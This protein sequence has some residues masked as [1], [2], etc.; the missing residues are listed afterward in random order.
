MCGIYGFTGKNK[1]LANKLSEIMEHRGPDQKGIKEFDNFTLGFRRLAIMDLSSKG[2][3]PMQNKDKSLHITFNGEVFNFQE[4]KEKLIKK[5][6]KFKSKTDSEV[7]LHAYEE[8]GSKCLSMFNGQFALCIYDTKNNKIFLARDRIGIRPLYYFKNGKNFM[9]S[10]EVKGILE[11]KFIKK[12]IDQN[13]LNH[14]LC[15]GFTSPTQSIFKNIKK[16]PPGNYASVNLE[17]G[18]MVIKPYWNLPLSK[19]KKI[20]SKAAAKELLK[21]FEKSISYRLISDRPVGAF[22]SGGLDSSMIV[23]LMKNKIPNLHTF[24]VTFDNKKYDESKYSKRVSELFNTKHHEIKFNSTDILNLVQEVFSKYDEPL[25]DPT[26]IPTY[27]VSKIAKTKVDVCLSGTGG[28]ELFG[29]YKRYSHFRVAQA[30]F[31]QPKII[32][33]LIKQSARLGSNFDN[34]F[35][36]LIPLLKE[37]S[38]SK[39]YSKLFTT[40]NSPKLLENKDHHFKSNDMSDAMYFDLKEYMPSNLL[41]KENIAGMAVSLEGRFPFLDHNLV[42]FSTTLPLKY[43][44]KGNEVKW[45]LKKAAEEILPKD[46]IYRKKQSFAVSYEEYLRKELKEFGKANIITE[47]YINQ[48]P[49]NIIKQLWD[50]HQKENKNNT[51]IL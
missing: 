47:N 12:E 48:I 28:D 3:Q 34:R 50:D 5:G 15:M 10:S 14:Y 21:E 37:E 11:S 19:P 42:E 1:K 9:Y 33:N 38:A 26:T 40:S 41:Y 23:A 18:K 39:V 31:K 25:A 30:Y 44:I 24:S 6:H 4:I 2:N 17:T 35:K 49:S 46:I 36:K 20:S 32:K 27:L 29:G 8:Y 7:V 51:D 43:K 16:L 22:L 45:I 13:A